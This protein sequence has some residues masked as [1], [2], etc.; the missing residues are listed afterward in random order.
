MNELIMKLIIFVSFFW[1]S[2]AFKGKLWPEI[3]FFVMIMTLKGPIYDY[4]NDDPTMTD[5]DYNY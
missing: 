5:D 3:K 2:Q 1:L 4:Q